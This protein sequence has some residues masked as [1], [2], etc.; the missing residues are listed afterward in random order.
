MQ[1]SR[2]SSSGRRGGRGRLTHRLPSR[3]LREETGNAPLEFITVGLLLL[4]PLVYL[5]LAVASIQGAALAIE[6]AARQA[7]RVYVQ[8]PTDAEAARRAET[9]IRLTLADA[10]L[11]HLEPNVTISCRP[12]PSRCLTRMGTV[13][14]TIGASI[15]LPLAPPVLGLDDVL[16]VPLQATATEQVSRFWGGP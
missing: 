5:I 6:G 1:R 14:I 9:A 8:A 3:L 2:H 12:V 16:A 10:G 11:D 13:T 15:P 7:T 4:V